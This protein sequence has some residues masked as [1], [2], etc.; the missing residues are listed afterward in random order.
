MLHLDKIIFYDGF[1]SFVPTSPNGARG[2]GEKERR[3][4]VNHQ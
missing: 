2:G 1:I 4:L 3:S